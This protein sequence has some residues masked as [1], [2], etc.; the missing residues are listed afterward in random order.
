MKK[1]RILVVDDSAL[2]RRIIRDII[3]EQP[4][5]E[6]A[7]TAKNG[8]EA[9]SKIETDRPDVVTL[10]LEMPEM[11]GFE[12]L[13]QIMRLRPLPVIMVSGHT[14]AGSEATLKALSAGALDFIPKPEAGFKNDAF[15]EFC[16]SL[17]LKIR[18][19]YSVK[20]EFISCVKELSLP[21]GK[22]GPVMRE[23]V[24]AHTIIA[25]GASTGGPK[26]LELLLGALPAALPAAVLLSVHMPPGFTLSFANRLNTLSPLQ[27]KEGA[28]GDAIHA[29]RALVA[30]G[31]YHMKLKGEQI[32]LDSG[33]KVNFVRPSIDVMLESLIASPYRIIVVM[34]TGMGKDGADGAAR[35]KSKKSDTV[36]LVQDPATAVIPSMPEAVMKS[37]AVNSVASID[38]MAS[39]ITR[40]AARL[41]R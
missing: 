30:P 25:V 37:A 31:G 27:V 4:D 8:L 21:T 15:E 16:G 32:S 40:Y 2:M 13:Q 1:I 5:M 6:L 11:D 28:E 41:P 36:I 12:T 19:A 23:T 7:G 38:K 39:E 18:A 33:M 29:G 34:L 20:P 35:L 26:A 22:N 14:R 17:P 9:L 10:D 3:S 24:P